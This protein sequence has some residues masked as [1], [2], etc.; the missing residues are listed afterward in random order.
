MFFGCSS[1]KKLILD[2]FNTINV[3]EMHGM[4]FG[5]RSLNELNLNKFK[6]YCDFYELYA[7]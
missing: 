3:I 7:L 6:I 5:C 2:N 4:F 1:L